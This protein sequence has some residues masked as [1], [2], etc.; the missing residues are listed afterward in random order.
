MSGTQPV[1]SSDRFVGTRAIGAD[2]GFDP[3]ALN[4]YLR[5]HLPGFPGLL[6]LEQFKGG[7]S[8]PTFKL[9]T[10]EGALV[11]RTKPG[12]ASKLLPTAHAID[13][14]YRVQDALRCAGI[15]VP[16][17]LLLCLDESVIG[18]AFYIMNF[19][20]GRVLWEQSLP[21]QSA[22]DRAS[23]YGEMNGVIAALHC[24]D[25][26]ALGLKDYGREENFLERQIRRWS[27]QY[28]ASATGAIE[29]MD[30]LIEWLPRHIPESARTSVIHG[31]YRLDNMVID[32][33]EPKIVAVLDWELSTLGDPVADFAYHCACYRSDPMVFRGLAGLDLAALGIP[34]EAAYIA[35]YA[36]RTDI[37]CSGHWDFYMAY[38]MFKMAAIMQGVAKRASMGLA[39]SDHAREVGAKAR[40][41]AHQGWLI[42]NEALS[43]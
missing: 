2:P 10:N 18:R 20:E 37:D 35:M 30:A 24:L 9:I 12:P 42:A 41:R 23:I 14:E 13:R 43:L 38:S 15:P 21:G 22:T 40:E 4:A 19:V 26:E 3:V 33:R 34:S 25:Y 17:M 11:M 29:E 31:E 39:S 5:Q 16:K 8:N 36:Q 28:R 1:S 27:A 32:E 7:Q 6:R